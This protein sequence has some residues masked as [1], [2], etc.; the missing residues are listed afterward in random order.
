MLTFN[1]FNTDNTYINR[2]IACISCPTLHIISSS[3][4]IFTSLCQI[5]SPTRWW[6]TS[7]TA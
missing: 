5:N 7:R 4:S 3:Y 1:C 6:P 2:T